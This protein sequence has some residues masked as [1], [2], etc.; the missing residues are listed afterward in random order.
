MS[1]D[2]ETATPPNSFELSQVVF[3]HAVNSASALSSALSRGAGGAKKCVLVLECDVIAGDGS[4]AGPWLGHEPCAG[5]C[6]ATH[7]PLSALLRA[8]GAAMRALRSKIGWPVRSS[9]RMQPTA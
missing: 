3:A 8:A 2:S 9:K 4:A 6:A 7:A 5:A 1:D